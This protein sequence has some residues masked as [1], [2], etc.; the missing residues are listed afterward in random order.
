MKAAGG[1]VFADIPT[2][3]D[4]EHNINAR[5][6]LDIPHQSFRILINHICNNHDFFNHEFAFDQLGNFHIVASRLSLQ[7]QQS[8]EELRK[9]IHTSHYIFGSKEMRKG[10]R[11]FAVVY[12]YIE[13]PKDVLHRSDKDDDALV[14][15]GK[16]C[17]QIRFKFSTSATRGFYH[18]RTGVPMHEDELGYD[19][20][21]DVDE[22]QDLHTNNAMLEEFDD[23][24]YEEKTF[25]MMWHS[26]LIS[27][28]VYADL[29]IPMIT[30]RFARK[31]APDLIQ[32]GLRHNFLLHLI[33]LW[34]YGLISSEDMEKCILYVDKFAVDGTSA[35]AMILEEP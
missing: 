25:M 32:L 4:E 27:F 14:E 23:V 29:Y 30:E 18:S 6:G 3:D 20:D 10:I 11:K 35:S 21:D 12:T 33:T 34:D 8:L 7:Q 5:Y 15:R 16:K 13:L 17:D 28:P 1:E 24:S 26:H 31:H 22:S 2:E 9:E 19:S